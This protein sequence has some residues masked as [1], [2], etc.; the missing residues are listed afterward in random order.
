MK[1]KEKNTNWLS[2]N[3]NWL[4][5][6]LLLGA[7]IILNFLIGN[8]KYLFH[9]FRFSTLIIFIALCICLV[10]IIGFLGLI[11]YLEDELSG[12]NKRHIAIYSRI[13]EKLN[14]KRRNKS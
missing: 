5:I 1:T 10:I 4:F 7:I 3:S 6:S 9:N 12:R 2:R 14:I 11:I 13:I 8:A